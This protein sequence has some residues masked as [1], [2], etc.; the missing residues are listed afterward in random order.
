MDHYITSTTIKTL[1][2]QRKMTQ[3]ELADILGVSPKTISKWETQGAYR[4]S[5][6][7]SPLPKR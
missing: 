2:E 3:A 1:R 7:W 4:T 6:S 5:L